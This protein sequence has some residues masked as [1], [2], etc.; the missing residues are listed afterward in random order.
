MA[1]RE[2]YVIGQEGNRTAVLL[3][4]KYYEQLIAALEEVESIRAYDE[5]KAAND[6]VIPFDQATDEIE[7]QR[8]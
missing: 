3:D 6:E 7:R 8:R 2:Q 1:E 5:A 4:V